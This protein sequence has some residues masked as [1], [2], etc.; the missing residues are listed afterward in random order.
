MAAPPL[1]YLPRGFA[2]L[3]PAFASIALIAQLLLIKMSTPCLLGV[4]DRTGGISSSVAVSASA[5]LRCV[6]VVDLQA[7]HPPIH[8][9]LLACKK[10]ESLPLPPSSTMCICLSVGLPVRAHR[11]AIARSIRFLSLENRIFNDVCQ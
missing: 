11:T 5:T 6:A 10:N 8:A 4:V 1:A 7:T 2:G 9:C 3:G